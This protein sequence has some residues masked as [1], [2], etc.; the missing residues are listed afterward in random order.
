GKITTSS[1]VDGVHFDVDQHL[2]FANALTKHTLNL[3][4]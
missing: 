2:N 1:V 3:I 4:L